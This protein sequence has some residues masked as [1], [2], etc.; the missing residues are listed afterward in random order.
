MYRMKFMLEELNEFKD[1]YVDGDRV[2]MFD[3]LIDLVYVATG[4]ALFMGID[5][6]Q[7]E[8]GFAAVHQANMA[9]VRAERPE[10][11]KRGSIF[12]VVKPE[13]WVS[14]EPTLAEILTWPKPAVT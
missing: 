14:P 11:S 12:D 1:A 4:T 9:K 7:W 5:P 10:Q 3:A 8:A 2:K 6:G 13:G